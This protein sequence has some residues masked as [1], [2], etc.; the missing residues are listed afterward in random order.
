MELW[1]KISYKTFIKLSQFH[2]IS[3][4]NNRPHPAPN[5]KMLSENWLELL[6][7]FAN[8]MRKSG[9]KTM[10]TTN[11]SQNWPWKTGKRG[12]LISRLQENEPSYTTTMLIEVKNSY[13]NFNKD[14]RWTRARI[15]ILFGLTVQKWVFIST[16]LNLTFKRVTL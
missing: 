16:T 5:E 6:Y 14:L 2:I 1:K 15:A 3:S 7:L 13:T 10:W 9:K 4:F 8:Y 11:S 12:L